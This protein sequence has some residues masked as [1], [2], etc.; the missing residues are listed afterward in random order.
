MKRRV[1][2]L[3]TLTFI[4]V[5]PI[6]LHASPS[7]PEVAELRKQ[8]ESLQAQVKALE[9]QDLINDVLRL[10]DQGK[11]TEPVPAVQ[12]RLS[13]RIHLPPL[14]ERPLSPSA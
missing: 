7:D 3:L 14:Q 6:P 9:A 11:L 5:A 13:L 12:R 1:L 4:S 8:V 10:T 2:L